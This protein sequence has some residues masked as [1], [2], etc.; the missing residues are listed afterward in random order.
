VPAELSSRYLPT[1]LRSTA[2]TPYRPTAVRPRAA[3]EPIR[4]LLGFE[5]SSF[6]PDVRVSVVSFHPARCQWRMARWMAR[7]TATGRLPVF[8]QPRAT[9]RET[10]HGASGYRTCTRA[11]SD[12]QSSSCP[13]VFARFGAGR[14]L[15]ELGQCFTAAGWTWLLAE[16]GVASALSTQDLEPWSS[17]MSVCNHDVGIVRGARTIFVMI[18]PADAGVDDPGREKINFTGT[19]ETYFTL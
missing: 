11:L 17:N 14:N 2:R 1:I 13:W 4:D 19:L 16:R 3:N 6:R 7:E 15:N 10:Q 18:R 12:C 8:R 9:C 5:A